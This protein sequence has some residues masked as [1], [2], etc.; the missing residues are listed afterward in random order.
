MKKNCAKF[1]IVET[2]PISVTHKQI[3]D[4]RL[5]R[6]RSG[7]SKPVP[8]AE[9]MKLLRKSQTTNTSIL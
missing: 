2:L 3:I 8:H 4:E 7:Q 6:Y 5:E 1:E 9:M